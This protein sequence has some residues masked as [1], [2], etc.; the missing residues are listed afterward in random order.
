MALA[1]SIILS[2][3][4]FNHLQAPKILLWFC[5]ISPE[6]VWLKRRRLVKM[7]DN[8]RAVKSHKM[9]LDRRK[10]V[11]AAELHHIY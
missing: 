3:P 9:A 4:F 10:V 2:P 5:H 11:Y 8:G 1:K 6:T 7:A